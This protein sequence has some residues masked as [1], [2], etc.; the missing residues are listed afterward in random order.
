MTFDRIAGAVQEPQNW[1]T[2]SG[3][4]QGT[5]YSTLDQIKPANAAN[6]DLKWVYQ[7]QSLEK[8]EATPLV[9]DGDHVHGRAAEHRGRDRHAHGAARTGCTGTRCRRRPTSA[10]AT[11]TADWRFSAIRCT[12][13]RSTRNWWRSISR[14]AA[15]SGRRKVAEYTKGYGITLAPLAVKDKIVV[16]PA[17]GERGIAGFLAAYDAKTGKEVWR[18]H[19]IPQPGEPGH[20][21]WDGDAWKTGGASVWVTG[22][23]DPELNLVYWGTGNPGPDWNPHDARRRQSVLRFGDRAG[24][25]YGQAEMVLPV[26]AARRMGLRFGAGSGAGGSDLEGQAAQGDV[27]G[28]SQ[29]LLL[30]ARPEQ[31]RVPVGQGIREADVGERNR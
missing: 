22:S 16:G 23:Y 13:A 10:A 3:S 11:S 17:G 6:L 7:A 15:R 24:C 31:R 1:L 8:F 14:P 28:E 9:V 20:E 25:G 18:F 30:R 2:Y 19:T 21:T 27:V 29:R 5:R 12:W 4:L 26:H